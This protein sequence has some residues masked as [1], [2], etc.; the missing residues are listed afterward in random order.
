MEGFTWETIVINDIFKIAQKLLELSILSTLNI[1]PN[2][3][4]KNY[5]HFADYVHTET[6]ATAK[7]GVVS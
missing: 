7:N 3:C 4:Y 6:T 1:L 5:I 2:F